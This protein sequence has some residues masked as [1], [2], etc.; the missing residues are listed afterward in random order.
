MPTICASDNSPH[1]YFRK[2]SEQQDATA[3]HIPLYTS[4]SCRFLSPP[5]QPLLGRPLNSGRRIERFHLAPQRQEPVARL[6]VGGE[7]DEFKAAGINATL[8][9]VQP[10]RDRA[11]VEFD[12]DV[13]ALRQRLE[14]GHLVGTLR[15]D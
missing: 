1:L 10:E 12:R 7:G 5:F 8:R 15:P 6:L 14:I 13:R 4:P 2:E 3:N 9:A 11:A